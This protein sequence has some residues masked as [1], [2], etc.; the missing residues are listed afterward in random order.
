MKY[1]L[2]MKDILYSMSEFYIDWVRIRNIPF[3]NGYSKNI[4]I[5]SRSL[6]RL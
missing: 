2:K 3:Q 1:D 5:I 4:D 6:N